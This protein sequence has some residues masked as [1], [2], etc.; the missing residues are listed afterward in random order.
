MAPAVQKH[1]MWKSVPLSL[2]LFTTWFNSDSKVFDVTVVGEVDLVNCDHVSFMLM[3]YK[4][5]CDLLRV[6]ILFIPQ[7]YICFSACLWYSV[8]LVQ[9][10]VQGVISHGGDNQE[11]LLKEQGV[12]MPGKPTDK[13]TFVPNTDHNKILRGWPFYLC[14]NLWCLNI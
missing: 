9:G 12:K 5:S 1:Q 11:T 13:R 3:L 8:L 6:H 4:L 2:W 10:Q 14:V 7:S